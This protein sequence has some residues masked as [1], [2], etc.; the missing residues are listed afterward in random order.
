[1]DKKK[2]AVLFG[3]CS[4]EYTVSLHSAFSVLTNLDAE[5]Y[6]IIPIGI[7]R[8]GEW[9]RYYGAYD[10][11][12]DD[13]WADTQAEL[14][15]VAV[16]PSRSVHGIVELGRAG[17]ATTRIDYA[18]PVLHGKNGEDGTV[19]GL[20]E[21]AGIPVIGCGTLSSA[22]CMDKDRAHKLS[23]LAGVTAPKAVTIQIYEREQAQEMTA[24]LTYPLFVKP[25]RAGS[26]YGITKIERPE[27]LIAAVDLAFE[28]DSQV[29]VEENVDG[30]EVGCAVIGISD[31]TVGRVDE[32]ELK[33]GFFDYAE[34][35]ERASA[36]IHMP[37]RID[38]DTE[39]R[40]QEAAKTV[41]RALD[42]SGFA[43]VDLFLTPSG[44]IVFNEVNSIPGLTT[45]SRFPN[46]L[47]GVGISFPEMLEKLIGLYDTCEVESH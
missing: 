11:L 32:I 7:T 36:E 9:Y 38:A 15:A 1:M 13:T 2:L 24:D 8:E 28:H 39:R 21:L 41:Y 35:Y 23:A 45:M 34:K 29:I 4:T 14:V 40:I 6:E 31:L 44:E 30:F 47:K 33:H 18:F 46:M 22:L 20:F 25:V 27:E 42:C 19:Q 10:K 12:M 43:R 37:A 5:K 3:G 16:S 17:A 26:S